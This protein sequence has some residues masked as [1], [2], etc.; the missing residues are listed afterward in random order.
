GIAQSAVSRR[1]KHLEEQ[2]DLSLFE[3]QPG[4]ARLTAPGAIFR[5]EVARIL[6]LV[7]EAIARA[8]SAGEGRLGVLRIGFTEMA[9]RHSV[10]PDVTT[11][12]HARTPGLE[13]QLKPLTSP[14]GECAVRGGD[15]DR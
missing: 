13:L 10:L 3:R 6:R 9:M 1:I 8:Q 14:D 15:V 4:G 11:P 7:E 5:D 12:F 2:L